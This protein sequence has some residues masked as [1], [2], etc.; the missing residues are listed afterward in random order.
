MRAG[1]PD[2]RTSVFGEADAGKGRVGVERVTRNAVGD[3]A[4]IVV[5][6]VGGDD[7]E[8]VVGGVGEGAAAVAVSDRP[9][10]GDVGAELVVYG[11]VAALVVGYAGLLEAEVV[12]VGYAANGKEDVGANAV[13]SIV[14]AVDAC[15]DIVAVRLEVDALGVQSN[16]DAL[17]F[18]EGLDGR[19]DVLVLARDE[20]GGLFDDGDFAAEAAEDLSEF[21]AY[22]A[23]ADDDEMAGERLEFENADVGHPGDLIDAGK[24]RHDGAAADVDEDLVGGEEVVADANLFWRFEVGVADEDGAVLHAAQPTLE[25][26]ARLGDDLVLARFHG[27]HVDCDCALDGDSVGGSGAGL[28]GDV[29]AGDHGLG[30]RASGVDAGATEELAFDERDGAAG[31][32]EPSC[33][34]RPGLAGADDDGVEVSW[35]QTLETMKRAPKMAI[36]SSRRATGRSLPASFASAARYG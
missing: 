32:R 26:V 34:G 9:D 13:G 4:R 29:G 10:A 19:G 23:S 16:R 30:G 17:F 28:L 11:D 20:A 6:Q 12:G 5:E 18:E 24:V 7:L 31:L 15:S 8:V 3:A 25:A 14:R 35:H 1:L 33:E 27:L 22:V 21:E 36:K 2:L